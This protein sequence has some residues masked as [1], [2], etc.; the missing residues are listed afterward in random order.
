M[1]LL[2]APSSYTHK[3]PNWEKE[4]EGFGWQK[5]VLYNK[6]HPLKWALTSRLLVMKKATDSIV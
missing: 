2:L 6:D 1:T 3:T 5:N 4:D